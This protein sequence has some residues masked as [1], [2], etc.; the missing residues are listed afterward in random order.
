MTLF[1]AVYGL[2]SAEADDGM[3]PVVIAP[4]GIM[5]DEEQRALIRK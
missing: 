1:G 5:D 3:M 4:A 2:V